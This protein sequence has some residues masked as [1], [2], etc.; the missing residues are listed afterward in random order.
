MAIAL[1]IFFVYPFGSYLGLLSV[2]IYAFWLAAPLVIHCLANIKNVQNVFTL[3]QSTSG[4]SLVFHVE[5]TSSNRIKIVIVVFLL[6]LCVEHAYFYPFFDK[7]NRIKQHYAVNNKHIKGI[8]TSQER[9]KAI[10]ELLE[11]SGKY[12]K[13]G[14]Y[15]LAYDCMPLF[16]YLTETKPY[17]RN[18]W[19][20]L[21][22]PGIFKAGVGPADAN[23]KYKITCNSLAGN[24][25]YRN[26]WGLAGTSS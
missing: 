13:P 20:Y 5:G 22:M 21:Y 23:R 14:D 19:P 6:A 16:H 17:M 7:R 4:F 26:R 18:S 15:V 2:G 11:E 1:F 10:N 24:T 8:Y 3:G 9:A 25:T 12:I